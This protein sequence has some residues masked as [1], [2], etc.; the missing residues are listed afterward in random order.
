[1]VLE[2]VKEGICLCFRFFFKVM[3]FMKIRD[4]ERNDLRWDVEN[5]ERKNELEGFVEYELKEWSIIDLKG[6][7]KEDNKK[8]DFVLENLLESFQEVFVEDVVESE[9]FDGEE[10]KKIDLVV[11]LYEKELNLMELNLLVE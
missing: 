8:V 2:D 3:F 6:V 10:D 9:D 1:M 11:D 7:V 5:K 4:K